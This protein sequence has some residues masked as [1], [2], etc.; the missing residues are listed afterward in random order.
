M[1]EH[2][3]ERHADTPLG[4]SEWP[5][6]SKF[7][8]DWNAVRILVAV[9]L[10]L[11]EPDSAPVRLGDKIRFERLIDGQLVRVQVRVDLDPPQIWNAYPVVGDS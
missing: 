3:L 2:I 11:A 8:S 9:D 5:W 4:R 7:P 6:K 10:A 1:R